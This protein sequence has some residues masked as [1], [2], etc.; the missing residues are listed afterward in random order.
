[1]AKALTISYSGKTYKAEFDRATAKAYAMTGNKP[2]DV[3]DNP[4]VALAPF[5][6][7]AFKKHQPAIS[8]KKAM[9]IYD[10]LGQSKKQLFREKLINSYVDTIKDLVGDPEATDGDEGNAVW[11]DEDED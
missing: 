2:T 9:E 6:H 7:C 10:A 8:E 5:I 1:M 11:E 4:F 3:F